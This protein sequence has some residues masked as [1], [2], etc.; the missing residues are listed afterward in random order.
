M[1][2]VKGKIKKIKE[3]GMKKKGVQENKN[4]MKICE[5]KGEKEEMR[6]TK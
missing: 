4:K 2:D 3:K 6:R 5:N 1:V